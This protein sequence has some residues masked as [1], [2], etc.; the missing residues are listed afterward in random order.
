[1]TV[2]QKPLNRLAV[3]GMLHGRGNVLM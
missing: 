1:V 3:S 2:S